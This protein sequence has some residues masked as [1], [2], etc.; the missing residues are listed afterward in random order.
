MKKIEKEIRILC[1]EHAAADAAMIQDSLRKGGLHFRSKRV[2]NPKAYREE[3]ELDP[4]DVILS[5][6]GVP[7]F[8]GT[9]ALAIAREICPD[10]PFI[11]VTGPLGEQKTIELFEQ[12]ATDCVLKHRLSNLATVVKRALREAAERHEFKLKEQKLRESEERYRSLIERSPEAIFVVQHG[13]RIAFANPAAVQLLGAA[14]TH[15]LIG[16]SVRK[17]FQPDPWDRLRDRLR[18]QQEENAP[19]EFVEQR[20]FQLNGKPR[21]AEVSVAPTVFQGELVLQV[22]AHDL[23]KTKQVEDRLRQSE[24]LKTAILETAL[25]AI[26]AIDHEGKVQEWNPAAERMF[27]Y[28]REQAMNRLVNELIIPPSVKKVYRDGLAEYLMSGAASLIGRP[29]ELTLRRSDGREFPAELAITRILMEAP[30]RFALRIQDITERK[31]AENALRESE[32]RFRMLVEGATDYAIY[33]LDTEGRVVTWNSGAERIEGYKAEEI[34]G[35]SLAMF[36]PAEDVRSGLPARLLREAAAEGKT[37]NEGWR[38][39]RGGSR[40]W[41]HGI[42]TALRDENGKLYGYCKIA[43]DITKQREAEAE[44][45]RLNEE[46]D[47][48][49]RQRTA[50]LELANQ[51]L[52]AFSYSVSHDLRAPLRHI[53][54]Y[55]SLLQSEASAKL[56]E[57]NRQHLQTITD[58]ANNLGN[59]IDA[60]LSFSRMGRA[61][62]NRQPMNLATVVEEARQELGH[63]I[64]GRDIDWQIGPLPVIEGDPLM[65]RQVMINLV[66]NALKYT[67]K[68]ERAKIEIGASET[69]N[70]TTVFIRDNGVGFDMEFAGKLFGVFQ[71]LHPA[72]EFE[73]IGIGLANV[74]RIIR[75]HGG[76]VRAEG[77]VDGGA[78]FSFSVPKKSKGRV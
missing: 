17:I 26:L 9:K 25:E 2:D 34:M 39:R 5:D 8:S 16:K 23:S 77:T 29:V 33:M 1:V 20:L 4:P 22:I 72:S 68:R 37:V 10:V 70:E 6:Y 32:E 61:E 76:S 50:E 67:R 49:V 21:P 27:G 51:E 19:A 3:L 46:L 14:R 40:F 36:F 74:W 11:F 12:G 69:A 71:R 75:R 13:D 7:A 30:A 43:H 59:L 47:Q 53:V 54:G 66:S 28:S 42:I 65:L 52:E 55:A 60:L 31:R 35:E 57:A 78:T 24:L 58:A 73:G 15:E 38:L 64:E 56:D 18:R 63:E 48:R 41:S 44:I 45:R 62:L